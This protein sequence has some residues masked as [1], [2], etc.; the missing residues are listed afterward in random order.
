MTPATQ[1]LAEDDAF[2]KWFHA[3]YAALMEKYGDQQDEP[4]YKVYKEVYI[5]AQAAWDAA[6]AQE[7]APMK[8]H[9]YRSDSLGEFD[10]VGIANAFIHIERTD[11][12]CFW[13]G[14]DSP[15][16][17]SIH[18]RTGIQDGMRRF[19]LEEDTITNPKDFLVERNIELAS[20]AEYKRAL[21]NF[22]EAA[23]DQYKLKDDYISE[24][25]A[26]CGD[27]GWI[28]IEKELPPD[29]V[30]AILVWYKEDHI[31]DNLIRLYTST[32]IYVRLHPEAYSHW[33]PLPAPPGAQVADLP[34][35][36]NH[37]PHRI[38]ANDKTWDWCGGLGMCRACDERDEGGEQ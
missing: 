25:E 8:E 29:S 20:K 7:Q 36:K 5:F 17:P 9:E 19:R 6:L 22:L 27:A 38:Y 23:D 35:R 31:A 24:L 37:G 4:P 3:N 34:D 33:R 11:E 30:E 32:A 15:G 13:I 2:T 14:I 16:K 1:K 10:E 21:A 28:D 26:R 18:I 12:M